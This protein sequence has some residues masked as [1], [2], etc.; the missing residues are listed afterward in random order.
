MRLK[1]GLSSFLHGLFYVENRLQQKRIIFDCEGI[2]VGEK[3]SWDETRVVED[4]KQVVM[5]E[6]VKLQFFSSQSQIMGE[7]L[8]IQLPIADELNQVIG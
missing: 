4:G 1:S 5:V 7:T 8:D 2:E 6:V 3:A